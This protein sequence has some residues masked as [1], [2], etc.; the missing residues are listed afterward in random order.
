M[1]EEKNILSTLT[2]KIIVGVLIGVLTPVILIKLNLAESTPQTETILLVQPLPATESPSRESAEVSENT[3]P[4]ED[5]SA[6][7]R[8]PII[9]LFKAWG[10]LDL[11]LYMS[12]WSL[13]AFQSSRK[14]P[15][16]DYQD[17]YQRRERFFDQL[18]SVQVVD[19]E[20]VSIDFISHIEAELKVKYS[21]IF[22]RKNG[23]RFSEDDVL[24][25]Y[26]V[27]YDKQQERWLISEN[28]DYIQ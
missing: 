14:T 15:S 6:T 8:E 27:K 28:Y 23:R 20:I 5:Y 18:R 16:R 22:N 7:V 2:G 3:P 21:M 9:N 26:V 4:K 25:R 10:K 1:S 17:I 11:D 12:Q 24:E 13:N 19:R